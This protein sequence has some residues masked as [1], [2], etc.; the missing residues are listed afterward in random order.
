MVK[1]PL[2]PDNFTHVNLGTWLASVA[3]LETMD[4]WTLEKKTSLIISVPATHWSSSV[5]SGHEREILLLQQ[6]AHNGFYFCGVL[7]GRAWCI[8]LWAESHVGGCELFVIRLSRLHIFSRSPR[9]SLYLKLVRLL[10]ACRSQTLVGESQ[11]VWI[12][13]F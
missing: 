6:G 7:P 3:S 13:V 4:Q 5:L 10:E 11:V 12:A 9:T 2:M 8:V 1:G